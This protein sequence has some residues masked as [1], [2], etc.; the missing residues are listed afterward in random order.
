MAAGHTPIYADI[1]TGNYRINSFCHADIFIGP[2]F[3]IGVY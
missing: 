2:G 3:F 1:D